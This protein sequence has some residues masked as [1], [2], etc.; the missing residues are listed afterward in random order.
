MNFFSSPLSP[1]SIDPSR[2]QRE[3]PARERRA[4]R[5][6][7]ERGRRNR[8]AARAALVTATSAALFFLLE[9]FSPDWYRAA[10]SPLAFGLVLVGVFHGCFDQVIVSRLRG[11]AGWE[12]IGSYLFLSALVAAGLVF[13]PQPT[14]VLFFLLSAHHF[15]EEE[16]GDHAEIHTPALRELARICVGAFALFSPLALHP[17]AVVEVVRFFGVH[18]SAWS[19]LSGATVA[20]ASLYCALR[21]AVA[22]PTLPM[23]WYGSWLPLLAIY[24][25]AEPLVSFA[26][27]FT[28]RHGVSHL[29]TVSRKLAPNGGF[30][31]LLRASAPILVSTLVLGA[32]LFFGALL[33]LSPEALASFLDGA[34]PRAA[35]PTA[36]AEGKASPTSISSDGLAVLVACLAALTAPHAAVVSWLRRSRGQLAVD[37]LSD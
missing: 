14:L 13:F 3:S 18:W 10:R 21:V 4:L 5:L 2:S 37:R 6:V 22:T 27:Y 29:A 36:V 33:A 16:L 31:S 25:I 23:S 30:L 20:A 15:G 28:L 7:S 35:A 24:V 26:V 11:R 32:V 1:A 34:L 17:D 12:F 8:T 19:P 9:L